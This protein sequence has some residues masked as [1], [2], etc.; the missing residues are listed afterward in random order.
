MIALLVGLT[1][2]VSWALI[3]HLAKPVLLG[4][5]QAHEIDQQ[6]AVL[7]QKQRDIHNLKQ[8]ESYLNRPDGEEYEA[9][10]Q[11][12]LKPG[13]ESLIITP[14]TTDSAKH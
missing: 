13:E 12:Y 9:R 3:S 4:I 6:E 7:A 10:T 11:G 1:G 8:Q 5:A 14:N 2:C